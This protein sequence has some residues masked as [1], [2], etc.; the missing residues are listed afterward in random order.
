MNIDNLRYFTFNNGTDNKYVILGDCLICSQ[1]YSLNVSENELNQIIS[2][3]RYIQDILPNHSISDREFLITGICSS[4]RLS[5]NKEDF[6]RELEKLAYRF[7][8]LKEDYNLFK[9][10]LENNNISTFYHFT[11]EANL[12]SINKYGALFSLQYLDQNKILIN[13]SGGSNYSKSIDYEKGLA[14]YIRLSFVKNH[15]MRFVALKEGRINTP[16]LLEI[17][18][19]LLLTKP[20]LFTKKNAARSKLKTFDD[21]KNFS[22]LD[23]EIFNKNYFDLSKEDKKKYQAEILIPE[24]IEK[25]FI[26]NIYKI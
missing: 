13:K 19:D 4:C 7:D 21:I 22:K 16:Y 18:C 6:H 14:N 23:F 11:D 25:K 26:K 15:P 20:S 3:D 1:P 24:R 2:G 17:D 8:E 9:E 12:P 10:M 5:D